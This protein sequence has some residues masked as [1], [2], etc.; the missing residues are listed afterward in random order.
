M[1]SFK[2]FNLRNYCK[3]QTNYNFQYH[4]R[5]SF[6]FFPDRYKFSLKNRYFTNETKFFARSDLP[7]IVSV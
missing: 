6:V 7:Y 3:T 5:Y 2:Y 1:N 4:Q